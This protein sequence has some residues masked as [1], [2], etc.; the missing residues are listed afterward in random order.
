MPTAP[1]TTRADR[2]CR[3]VRVALVVDY[4]SKGWRSGQE[5]MSYVE[6]ESERIGQRTGYNNVQGAARNA[7]LR[8]LIGGL[9]WQYMDV[10]QEMTGEGSAFRLWTITEEAVPRPHDAWQQGRAEVVML[11]GDPQNPTVRRHRRPDLSEQTARTEAAIAERR[12]EL[13]GGSASECTRHGG[14]ETPRNG[15]AAASLREVRPNM[16]K[17]GSQVGIL[18]CRPSPTSHDGRRLGPEPETEDGEQRRLL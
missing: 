5:I 18:A 13:A 6:L 2:K 8:A 11:T 1:P 16:P 10:D 9:C 15:Q 14:P 7:K 17:G 3:L 12:E 4:L